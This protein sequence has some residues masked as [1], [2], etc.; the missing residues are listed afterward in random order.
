[1]T[2]SQK[3]RLETLAYLRGVPDRSIDLVI[4]GQD[5]FPNRAT[6]IPFSKET[7]EEQIASSSA[8]RYVLKSLGIDTD[9]ARNEFKCPDEL[10]MML[11][12][13]GVVVLNA[14]YIDPSDRKSE[15]LR[16]KE[17]LD[18][19]RKYDQGILERAERVVLC[20]NI[21]QRLD[22][23]SDD[24]N[25]EHYVHPALRNRNHPDASVRKKW[26]EQWGGGS[27]SAHW[28]CNERNAKSSR[29]AR[30]RQRAD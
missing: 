29:L 2:L 22:K 19:S 23:T 20:G 14:S 24:K 7:W 6:G 9:D 5:P 13:Q 1:M 21:A 26:H 11:R 8:G 10:F 12:N 18:E 15:G 25:W 16:W 17:V 27:L 30:C 3:I 4:V 28:S